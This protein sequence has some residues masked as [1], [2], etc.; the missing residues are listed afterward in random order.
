[1]NTRLVITS[2]CIIALL[3]NVI[4]AQDCKKGW[5]YETNGPKKWA[6][7]CPTCGGHLQSPINFNPQKLTCSQSLPLVQFFNYDKPLTGLSVSDNGHTAFISIPPER[8]IAISIPLNPGVR[9]KLSQIHFHWGKKLQGSEHAFGRRL[10]PL[11]IHFVHSASPTDYAVLGAFGQ[12]TCS[13]ESETLS[14]IAEQLSKI[15]K[16]GDKAPIPGNFNLND[17]LPADKSSFFTYSGSLTTPGCSEFVKWTVF[18]GVVNVSPETL[19][20]LRNLLNDEQNKLETT[21]RPF[22]R[23]FG[24]KVQFRGK[25]PP[26]FRPHSSACTNARTRKVNPKIRTATTTRSFAPSWTETDTGL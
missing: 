2:T 10:F 14:S 19:E 25:K 12:V 4:L 18:S 23:R 3:N 16:E 13:K 7:F 6:T 22:Q 8:D 1:M 5:D 17:L 24:R 26:T 21:Y 11:E 9:Y 20:D 15:K